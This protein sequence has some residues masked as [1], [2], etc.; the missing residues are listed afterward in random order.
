MKLAPGDNIDLVGKLLIEIRDLPTR[1]DEVVSAA[2]DQEIIV[3]DGQIPR[4]ML[5]PLARD[6]PRV[7][8]LHPG[9]IQTSD[10]FDAPLPATGSWWPKRLS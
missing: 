2:P 3:T 1:F 6:G 9:A 10:D 7:P 8:G 4:A 5:I